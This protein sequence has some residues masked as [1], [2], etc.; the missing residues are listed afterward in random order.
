MWWYCLACFTEE[1]HA[2]ILVFYSLTC[3]KVKKKKIHHH[4]RWEA[5]EFT[6]GFYYFWSNESCTWQNHVGSV[7]RI[8]SLTKSTKCLTQIVL[9]RMNKA[10]IHSFSRTARCNIAQTSGVGGPFALPHQPVCVCVNEWG[11]RTDRIQRYY[12]CLHFE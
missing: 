4:L 11:E 3:T 9:W 7:C 12:K 6:F 8:V 10:S 1:S 5:Y 2:C